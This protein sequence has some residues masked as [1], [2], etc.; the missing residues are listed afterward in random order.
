VSQD[1]FST[2]AAG[3]A[4]GDPKTRSTEPSARQVTGSALGLDSVSMTLL[5]RMAEIDE[6]ID[7]TV[8]GGP[9]K[10]TADELAEASGA[11]I[12][13]VH[14]FVQWMGRPT[15]DLTEKRYTDKDVEALSFAIAHGA[16]EGLS[17]DAMG[18]MVRS[19]SHGLQRL[20][21]RQV[22]AIIQDIADQQ[23]VSDTQARLLAG[24]IAPSKA[25]TL[26][27]LLNHIWKR[28]Y[29]DVVRR[30]TISAI[31]QRGL[32]NDDRDYPLLRV[33][34]FGDLVNFT[35]RT[36]EATPREF[37]NL[38]RDFSD[39]TWD[40]IT[41]NGG[42]VINYIGDA[43]FFVADDIYTGAQ[44]SLA[45]A[46]HG[47]TGICGP[48]RVGMVWTRV[49]ITHGDVFGPGVNLASRITGVADPN[50]VFIG[51]AAA[52]RLKHSPEFSVVAQPAFEARGIGPV[53]PYR[54]RYA[55]DPRNFIDENTTM[56]DEL[57]LP[58]P[59]AKSPHSAPN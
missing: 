52:A 51:P 58:V 29:A 56:D 15:I 19:V 54:L 44:V 5:A 26:Q 41:G 59:I 16:K 53:Q 6:N 49:L 31:A 28:Q 35:G 7:P 11:P 36:N 38:V 45:L 43:V 13:M 47:K 17:P 3:G 14:N 55:D 25:A 4:S 22:D 30:L 1:T 21:L 32:S 9:L 10:Y 39:Q 48:A 2:A 27:P 8:F 20:A 42:R 23:G 37:A 40:I 50:E 34:G 33:V 24:E 12:E 46:E 18:T 57:D